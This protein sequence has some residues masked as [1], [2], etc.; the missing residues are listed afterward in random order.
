MIKGLEFGFFFLLINWDILDILFFGVIIFL[1]VKL[2][3]K[4]V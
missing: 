3:I 1:L 2:E 4:D